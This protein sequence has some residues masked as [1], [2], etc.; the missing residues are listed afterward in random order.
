ME[1]SEEDLR[2][3]LSTLHDEL[4]Q[5]LVANDKLHLDLTET[6]ALLQLANDDL[7]FAHHE[8]RFLA[9]MCMSL[10]KEKEV[11]ALRPPSR[12]TRASRPKAPG[13]C[14]IGSHTLVVSPPFPC[15]RSSCRSKS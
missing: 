10:R 14:G 15:R 1:G 12:V 4:E 7:D 8:S 5:S 13:M 11:R 6:Q 3:A 2:H 9:R